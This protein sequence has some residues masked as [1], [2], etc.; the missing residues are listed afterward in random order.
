[1]GIGC[2]NE[3]NVLT[4]FLDEKISDLNGM[5]ASWDSSVFQWS[6]HAVL[7]SNKDVY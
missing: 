3:E 6:S 4:G 7:L 2:I 5:V 1:M